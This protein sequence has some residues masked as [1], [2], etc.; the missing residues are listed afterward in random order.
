VKCR[1]TLSYRSKKEVIR[2]MVD[3]RS[4]ALIASLVPPGV[5][6]SEQVGTLG[7]SL[8]SGESELLSRE[9]V[10]K[11]IKEFTAGRTCAR[12]ALQM[13]GV[14]PAPILR[15]SRG[16]P[17]WPKHV[18][19]SITHCSV[20][21]AAAVTSLHLYRSLGIDAELH[22][23]LPPGVLEMIARPEERKWIANLT[24][25]SE[26]CLDRLLFSVKESLYK[27]WY[28]LERCWLDF[29][30]ASVEIDVRARLFRATLD[31]EGRFC[32]QV[33]EGKYTASR[34]LILTCAWVR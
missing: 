28:P 31:H 13:L 16:E 23:A 29:Q 34:S 27:V 24:E 22:E 19:G 15:G 17:Q 7:G 32:P 6:C 1:A 26:V 21:C 14:A 4:Q 10:N 25:E 5:M 18:I 3:A 8:L 2:A 12:A 30:Q 20:Y 33:L 11:R 9:A